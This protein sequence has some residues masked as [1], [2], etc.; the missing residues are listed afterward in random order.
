MVFL[1]ILVLIFVLVSLAG[2]VAEI[3]EGSGGVVVIQQGSCPSAANP[4]ETT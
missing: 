1:S 3:P 2:V 4:G